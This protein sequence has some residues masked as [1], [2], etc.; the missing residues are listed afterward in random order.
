[1]LKRRQVVTQ[2]GWMANE[3]MRAVASQ[4][5]MKT[6]PMPVPFFFSRKLPTKIKRKKKQNHPNKAPEERRLRPPAERRTQ[7]DHDKGSSERADTRV[8]H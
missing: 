3:T 6:Q 5:L 7:E 2:T 1:M 8:G 4:R